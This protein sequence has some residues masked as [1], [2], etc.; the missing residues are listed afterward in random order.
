M[1]KE[2]LIKRI[3][4]ESVCPQVEDEEGTPYVRVFDVLREIRK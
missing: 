3:L 2:K 1:K 4:D